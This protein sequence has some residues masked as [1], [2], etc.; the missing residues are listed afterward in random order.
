[1]VIDLTHTAIS[2]LS[3][4][5]VQRIDLSARDPSMPP[6]EA[7]VPEFNIKGDSRK[8]LVISTQLEERRSHM[9]LSLWAY[10]LRMRSVIPT[11]PLTHSHKPTHPPTHTQPPTGLN[12]P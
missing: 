11:H 10:T 9:L 12:W 1:M 3:E 6:L 4:R 2:W 8:D 7:T 5:R